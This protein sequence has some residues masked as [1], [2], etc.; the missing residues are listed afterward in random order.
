[1]KVLWVSNSPIGP[2]A[3]IL[4]ETYSGTSGGWI[5]S[6]YEFLDKRNLEMSFLCFAPNVSKGT[7]LEKSNAI[8]KL[9]ALIVP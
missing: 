7:V 1:M 5:E 6:E 8:G 9:Y 2:A 3:N 4:D